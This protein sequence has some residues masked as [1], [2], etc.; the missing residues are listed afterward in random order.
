VTIPGRLVPDTAP[1]YS[2]RV[3]SCLRPESLHGFGL[4]GGIHLIEGDR[5]LLA[6]SN[7]A[8]K[9]RSRDFGQQNYGAVGMQ[10]EFD[11]IFGPEVE[12]IP[13]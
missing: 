2:C 12:M 6:T 1:E 4:N 9:G 13:D 11:P 8:F 7:D 10:E 5:S 3:Q